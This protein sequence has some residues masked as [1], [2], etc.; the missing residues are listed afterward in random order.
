RSKE[1]WREIRAIREGFYNN[2]LQEINVGDASQEDTWG[3]SNEWALRSGFGRINY[4]YLGRYLF[5]AN[6]R[7]DGSSRFAKGNRFGFF[8]SFSAGWRISEEPFFNIP[9]ISELK[10]RGSWGRMGNQDIDLYSYYPRIVLGGGNRDYIFGDELVNGA[11]KEALANQDISW[12]KTTMTDF[13][14]DASF[15]DGRLTCVGD[16]YRKDTTAMLRELDISGMIGLDPPV[17]NALSIRNTGWE[18]A[19]GWNDAVGDFYYSANFNVSQNRNKVLDLAD[20]GP[21]IDGIWLI[22]E[23]QPLGTMCGW[24]SDGLFQTQEEVDAHAKQHPVTGPGD[25]R[26]V[27]Q[28]NDGVINE[29]D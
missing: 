4:S 25:I 13:G 18:A 20:A 5:E 10:V 21:F 6:A 9:W 26:Y 29:A 11:A 16:I 24:E 27:D 17:Q 15:F 23:G 1:D 28:N 8:P 2:E 22:A 14:I 19:L 12:E 7:Y 3:T